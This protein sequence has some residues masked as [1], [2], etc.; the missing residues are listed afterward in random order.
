MPE[1]LTIRIAGTASRR[2]EA[3]PDA[4]SV[5]GDSALADAGI[6]P[7]DVAAGFEADGIAVLAAGADI[8][9]VW[10]FARDRGL[11]GPVESL[12]ATTAGSV[13]LFDRARTLLANRMID[14]VLT[15]EC[16]PVEAAALVLTRAGT[17][18]LRYARLDAAVGAS[19]AD[20]IGTA[21]RV[22][23]R[24]T[25]IHPRDIGWLTVAGPDD[26]GRMLA[27]VAP[28]Y[29]AADHPLSTVIGA[30]EQTVLGA[31]AAAA[32]HVYDARLPATPSG[33]VADAS[34]ALCRAEGE[35]PWVWPGPAGRRW[36]AVAASDGETA[37]HLVLSTGATK[38][39]D[40]PLDWFGAGGAL[41]LVL[42]GDGGPELAQEARDCL[43]RLAG[44]A[45]P[46]DLCRNRAA[47]T[48]PGR[49]T[50]VLVAADRARLR[51]ELR[52]AIHDLPEVIARHGEWVTPSGSYCT[53]A[54]LGPDKPV[55]LVYP[56]IFSLYPGAGRDLLRLFPALSARLDDSGQHELLRQD[57]L[58]PRSV[59][60]LDREARTRHEARLLDDIPGQLGTAVTL[61]ILH[62]A[63]I[64]DMLGIPVDGAFGCS[65]G[66]VSMLFS[67]GVWD[68]SA[69]VDLTRPAPG[70]FTERLGGRKQVVRQPWSIPDHVPDQDV[71]TTMTVIGD[72]A[73]VHAA[74][75]RFDRVY[76][77][78]VNTPREFVLA[79][80]PR[81]CRELAAQ[82]G[83]PS[84]RGPS[85]LVVHCAPAE[86]E[87]AAI[88]RLV[89]HPIMVAEPPGTLLT[90]YD[91]GSVDLGDRHRLAEHIVRIMCEP[92][93]FPRL[94]R[95]AYD[96]GFRYFID[97]G[98][99]G[100]CARWLEDS[101]ADVDH[102]AVAVDRR[103]M[104]LGTALA[105]A[106]ARL[107]SHGLPI[108]PTRLL[109][110]AQ[111][112]DRPA[113][114]RV[115]LR[116]RRRSAMLDS[117][118]DAL[119]TVDGH[120]AGSVAAVSVTDPPTAAVLSTIV[121]NTVAA[122]QTFVAAY[123]A[124]E[125]LLGG[126]AA[127]P[128][129]EPDV[130]DLHRFVS[131]VIEMRGA[132]G[133]LDT[134]AGITAEYDIPANPWY[135]R[136]DIAPASILLETTQC[137]AL[138]LEELGVDQR[139]GQS[140]RLLSADPVFHDRLPRAGQTLR[141]DLDVT[142]FVTSDS[143]VQVHF[144]YR[145]RLGDTVIMDM[146]DAC[147][148]FGTPA[149]LPSGP[150]A[151]TP[152]KGKHRRDPLAP[153]DFKPLERTDR[154]SL[155]DTDVDLLTSGNLTA[156]FGPAWDQGAEGCNSSIRLAA[157]R[158]RMLDEVT[159][160]ERLGGPHGL[161]E[162]TANRA[163]DRRS[164]PPGT[165]ITEGAAQLL[166]IFAMYLGLHLVFPDAEF[167][168]AFGI[169][170]TVHI[171]G[172][173]PAQVKTLSYRAEVTD[174][175]LLPRPTVIAD[176]T[177]YA[178]FAPI[179]RITD[180]AIQVMEKP[181]TPVGP[182]ASGIVPFLGRRN[183]DGEAALATEF[184]IAHAALGDIVTSMGPDFAV[185]AG[186]RLPRM[187]NRIFQFVDRLQRVAGT[188]GEFTTGSEASTEFVSAPESW[189][190]RD[191]C[192]DAMPYAVLMETSL[193][194]AILLGFYLGGA[195]V[196]A[197]EDVYV[198]NLDGVATVVR[199][200]DVRGKTI[201]Q[202]TILVSHQAFPGAVLQR[203]SYRLF[204]DGE[205]FYEGESLFGFFG[206]DGLRNQVGLDGGAY[207]PSWLEQHPNPPGARTVPIGPDNRWFTPQPGTGLRLADGHLRLI[208][209]ATVV[210]DGGEFGKG[211]VHGTRAIDPQDWYFQYHFFQDPV[212]PGS[213]GIEML[214][215]ALQLY[216]IDND[217]A[218]DMG[219]V[220]F[221]SAVDV[222]MRWRYRGQVLADDKEIAL[223][224]TVKEI[225]REPERLLVIADANVWKPGM[226]IYQ[227]DD[228]AIE[229]RSR[230]DQ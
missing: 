98:P 109:G 15:I 93:D 216:V 26:N 111:P 6:D 147:A 49:Y 182:T 38:G 224:V 20:A 100:S 35:Q 78:H 127:E 40:A 129:L 152:A 220:T 116:T 34:S 150:V 154:I 56:G 163:A 215:Q 97:I 155:T 132:P 190:Y 75:A 120:P 143:G 145:C 142:R 138:L 63:L 137:L 133:V 83:Y 130:T 42:S 72:S 82:L 23:V 61:A 196:L 43:T 73:E 188:R 185:F 36:A 194:S 151:A 174:I 99:G 1:L 114:G 71:W 199:P 55:A 68:H 117:T 67:H 218:A 165:M 14:A 227:V 2:T 176:V 134:P 221:E 164:V 21:A 77:T 3:G 62:T 65:L 175:L 24:H 31:V 5:V 217:L 16:G 70:L 223:D 180:A 121:P 13:A 110:D 158:I 95:A 66:E 10:R 197:D 22:A 192:S 33:V 19:G 136:D 104:P 39:R 41:L 187:P 91:Y 148:E 48:T 153:R 115:H 179:M 228:I 47:R 106:V 11:A 112:T 53:T 198:R 212:M 79:G 92:V 214:V 159:M 69:T 169:R 54:P 29:P 51:S 57:L 162:L 25:G 209:Q 161:G 135:T 12:P 74:V 168:P 122:H 86:T 28:E 96:H 107:I 189:Y 183:H 226:R 186:R 52:A 207:K 102:L 60:G 76:L 229:V 213:L 203:L 101:L 89:D 27:E 181:G 125:Q 170:E 4:L 139:S 219:P 140:L 18:D 131:R 146:A 85:A 7:I 119:I 167:Q 184:N 202:E 30:P 178:D 50:A 88:A 81:Q 8:D 173:M 45:D 191:N 206:A 64:R 123:P 156:V 166:E 17:D 87:A 44:G 94:A 172:S 124:I 80:D 9:T 90:G 118:R 113:S 222:P 208:D 32:R 141:V 225:R 211:Y 105:R 204:A 201:R 58:Y 108:D 157:G 59:A 205:V 126:R 46:M 193:Q 195:L 37:A 160:I 128:T 84:A 144:S 149:D 210:P 177:V 103:G 230:N 200:I 171:L